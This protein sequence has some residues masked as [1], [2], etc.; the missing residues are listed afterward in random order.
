MATAVAEIVVTAPD[1][2]S[3]RYPLGAIA[4]I[5]RHFECQVKLDDPMASRKHCKVERTP[6]GTF[7][8]E[9]NH[10]NNG[11]LL[12]G[13]PLQANVPVPLH[14][15]DTITVGET[16]LR[17][18]LAEPEEDKGPPSAVKLEDEEVALSF[19]QNAKVQAVSE[20]EI[21]SQDVN[22]LKSV[23]KRL[24]FLVEMGQALGSSLGLPKLL[25]TCIDK[26]FEVF[27]QADRAAAVIYGPDG[28]LPPLVTPESDQDSEL[29]QRKRGLALDVLRATGASQGAFRISRT[30]VNQVRSQHI[31]VLMEKGGSMSLIDIASGMCSPLLA[32]E[33]DL[34]LLYLETRKAHQAFTQDDLG[35]MTALAGQI[36]VV[37]SNSDLARE[38]A[39]QAAYREQLSRF[40]TPQLVD[41]MLKGT[42][43]PD[44]GGTEKK[45]T[46]IFS[47]IVGF[48]KLSAKMSPKDVMTL[49]NRY[50][51]VMQNII[52]RLGGSIDK[53]AGDNIMAHWGVLGDVPTPTACAV[54]AAVEMQNALFT[55]NRDEAQKKEIALPP[56]PLG[57]GIGLNTGKLC[58]GNIGSEHKIEFTVI[59]DPVNVSAR[60]EGLAGRGNIFVGALCWEE[61]KDVAFCI[62]MPDCTLKNVEKP[63]PVFSVRGI[64]PHGV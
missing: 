53:C 21:V 29:A 63:K 47:D 57:H 40:L 3:T 28:S 34:G 44:L 16:T 26:L 6:A 36:A 7:I 10:S 9:D 32:G 5:G 38:A 24:K 14:G 54:T 1:G 33:K 39:A 17:L 15:G 18:E 23:A 31:S 43:T 19:V 46:I 35:I 58:A 45:G 30:V 12:N 20:A 51:T 60:L 48:T 42:V 56:T 11:T 25:N 27:P 52:F 61:V 8:V 55:F 22:T 50:F 59:G 4:L 13:E 37:V 64:I 41:Q 49:L 62:R 2:S